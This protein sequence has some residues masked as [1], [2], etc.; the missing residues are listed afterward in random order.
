MNSVSLDNPNLVLIVI[1]ALRADHL[2][3][4]GYEKETSPTINRIAEDGTFFTRVTSTSSRSR[5]SLASLM[6]SLH[7]GEHEA[8][9]HKGIFHDQ[10]G[11][12]P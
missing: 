7:P 2:G 5:P 6:T 1:D 9:Y 8:E 11:R 3:C 10:V 12:V 4:Y